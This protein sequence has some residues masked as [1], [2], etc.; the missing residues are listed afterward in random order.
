LWYDSLVD[1]DWQ[2]ISLQV[3]KFGSLGL[4]NFSAKDVFP[5]AQVTY[6]KRIILLS[7]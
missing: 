3:L 1:V 7:H 2:E 5:Y 6:Q 4:Y